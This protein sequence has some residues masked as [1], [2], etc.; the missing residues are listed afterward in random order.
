MPNDVRAKYEDEDIEYERYSDHTEQLLQ[1]TAEKAK[2]EG[3]ARKAREVA[4]TMIADGLPE[5][6]ILKY[7][8]LTADELAALT[9]Q[10]K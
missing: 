8:G 7:S 1:E 3:I 9:C 4:L 10:P 6:M 2:A 5:P